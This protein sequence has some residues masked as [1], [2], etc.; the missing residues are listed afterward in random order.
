[1]NF[2]DAVDRILFN[3]HANPASLQPL[4]ILERQSRYTF[5]LE[6]SIWYDW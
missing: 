5:S 2:N 6:A 1:L 4:K 3:G